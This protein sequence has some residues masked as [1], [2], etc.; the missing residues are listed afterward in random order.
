MKKNRI[1]LI[2]GAVFALMACVPVD[3]GPQMVTIRGMV[4]GT[5][6][7]ITYFEDDGK[8]FREAIDS[9]FA[10]FN[11]S[12]SFYDRTSL[13]SRINRNEETRVDDYF[14]TVFTRAQEIARETGGA[15]DATIFPLV[16]AWGFGLSE[17]AEMDSEKVDSLLQFVGFEMVR[18]EYG[19][20][21][22]DDPRVQLDFNA[23]AKGYAADVVGAYL[24]EQG[25]DAWLVEIG[26]DLMTRG[27]KPDG[28]KWRIGLEIPADEY[29]APQDWEYYVEITDRGLAT[30]GDYR[31]FYEEGGRRL[32]HTIDPETG[33]PV[34]HTLMS[35]SVFA[36]DGMSADAYATAFMVMGLEDAIAFVEARDDLEAYF[37]FIPDDQPGYGYY[38]STGLTLLSRDDL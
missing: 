33:Y 31:R 34:D 38:A 21:V 8:V 29:D 25:T 36:P 37:I 28:S 3:R 24:D 32:S 15:F 19:H 7:T 9:I 22:K 4:F 30:S 20:L 13:L 10:E 6:Y 27:I 11:R 23:I 18:L 16:N 1:V 14:E 2:L 17:R 26:G 12:L 35:V 5:Y